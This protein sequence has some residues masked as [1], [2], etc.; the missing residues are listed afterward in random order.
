[1]PLAY[2]EISRRTRERDRSLREKVMS[3]D[4]A[5]ALVPD[6]AW[7]GI[8][9]STLSRTPMAMVWA[10]IRARRRDLVC[11]R[12][13]SS[14]EGELLFAAGVSRHL[15]TSWFSLGIVWGVSR[16]MR[17]YTESNRARF[18]EWSHMAMGMRFRA[19]AMAVPFLPMRSM[20]G[21]DVIAQLPEARAID[22]PFTGE[23]LVL[24]PA[25]NPDFAL[26]HVQRCDAY[27]NAQIDG[28]PFMD[29]DLALAANQVILT[30]ERIVS[31]DQIRRRPDHTKIPFFAVEAVVEAPFGC[32]PHE[33]YGV[34]E[35]L[36]DHLDRYA[37]A[38][39]PDA[40]QGIRDYL[41]HYF[42]E[43]KS[44]TEYL[45]RIGLPDL[46]DAARRGKSIYDD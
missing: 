37:A 38:L 25:L 3:L 27:G 30:T 40:E 14:S 12:G 28:L 23:K 7:V 6:G 10:L 33:C 5:A 26:I 32:A 42:F 9:G 34:Y 35:P 4:E 46:L 20:L 18:E 41:D 24:V 17:A 45:D 8:G 31:N 15:I 39:K 19:G 1:M 43:P 21:S 13:I 22:C 44:W 36:F 11:A 29:L 2:D 16:I